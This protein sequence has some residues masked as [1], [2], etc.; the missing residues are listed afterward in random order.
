MKLA[1]A[2][3]LTTPRVVRFPVNERPPPVPWP[4]WMVPSAALVRVPVPVVRV[5]FQ[6]LLIDCSRMVPWL[7]RPLDTLRVALPRELLP[8]TQIVVFGR[9]FVARVVLPP[10]R[11]V[12][13]A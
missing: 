10:T 5:S 13:G 2:P 1:P 11:M 9:L 12:V 4:T 3:T 7:T 6:L 8:C